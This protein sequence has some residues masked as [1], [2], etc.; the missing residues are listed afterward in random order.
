MLFSKEGKHMK[1]RS[2]ITRKMVIYF[3][4]IVIVTLFMTCEFWVQFRV[5]KITSQVITTANVCGAKIDQVPEASKEIVR[6][7]RNKVTLMLGML[8]VVSAM[9]FIMFVKNLIGPLNH[10]VKAAHKIASGDLRESIEL[11]TNDELAEVGEL[12]N[13][14]TAN[15][16]VFITNTLVYLEDIQKNVLQCKKSLSTISQNHIGVVPSE[17]E[18]GLRETQENLQ[19]LKNLLGEFNLYEVQMKKEA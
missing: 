15:I 12:I 10:M 1:K 18:A 3:S 17:A 13:D 4:L 19:E 9:V 7:W 16:Q 8:V 6:Y 14:L 5:D 2:S 11:E